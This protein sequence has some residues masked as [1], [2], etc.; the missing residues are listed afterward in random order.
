MDMGKGITPNLYCDR[1]GLLRALLVACL[2]STLACRSE[3]AVDTVEASS[4][5]ALPCLVEGDEESA[6]LTD[7]I[8][9][10][11]TTL[12]GE[13]GTLEIRLPPTSLQVDAADPDIERVAGAYGVEACLRCSVVVRGG[14]LTVDL[15]IVSPDRAVLWAESVEGER[16]DFLPALREGAAR[17]RDALAG[18]T[19]I[20]DEPQGG[21]QDPQVEILLQ[22]GRYYSRI[23]DNRH[24]PAE[25]AKAL[26]AFSRALEIDPTSADAAAEI[27]WLNVFRLEAEV[28]PTRTYAEIGRWARNALELDGRC[29][30]AWLALVPVDFFG[31]SAD[32]RKQLEYT[33]RGIVLAPEDALG[34]TTLGIVADSYSILIGREIFRRTQVLDPLYLQAKGNEAYASF[35]LE[36]YKEALGLANEVLE[37]EPHM[38]STLD[39][40][41]LALIEL[42]KVAEASSSV[43]ELQ[44]LADS[45]SVPPAY[46]LLA[47]HNLAWARGDPTTARELTSELL[48]LASDVSTSAFA[49]KELVRGAS[50][51]LTAHGEHEAA[52]QLLTRATEQGIPLAYDWLSLHSAFEGISED[53]Q[54]QEIMDASK[55][56]FDGFLDALEQARG[57]GEFPDMLEPALEELRT[58]LEL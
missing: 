57:R 21:P 56:A 45:G 1:R 9:S 54:F 53:P 25:F 29:A 3:P 17:V 18:P 12:L 16:E 20:T 42:G 39:T 19:S 35:A 13:A 8:P 52:V 31:P 27:A 7:A 44:E 4:L 51:T 49:L 24:E 40:K 2:V 47:R 30:R 28:E 11:L 33:F 14:S 26:A 34:L 15:E 48:T 46:A 5:V 36:Q 43:D 38:F 32:L 6:F 10:T 23:Y 55:R 41:V 58:R 22:Q 50:P 37:L